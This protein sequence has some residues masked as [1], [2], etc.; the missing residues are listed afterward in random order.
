LAEW[1]GQIAE[2]L[3]RRR[4]KLHPRKT[5]TLSTAE[6][7][8]FLGYELHPGGGRRLPGEGVE[9]ARNRLRGVKDRL[10]ADTIEKTEARAK[11]QAWRAHADFAHAGHFQR[12]MLKGLPED[13]RQR[14]RG[15]RK[16]RRKKSGGD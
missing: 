1:R 14:P 9:R 2:F 13:M 12:A 6:P 3:A 10:K 11:V 7:A 4:L 15:R 16:R 8:T 5:V